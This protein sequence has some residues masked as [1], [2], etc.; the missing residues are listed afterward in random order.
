MDDFRYTYAVARIHALDATLLDK[1]FAS[2]MIAAEPDEILRMLGETV[3]GENLA[4]VENPWQ[5]ERAL[6]RE[7]GK[8]Y[9]LL[10]KICPDKELIRLFR[11]RY[12]FHNLKA[13]LKSR[14]TEI[15]HA[16]SVVDLGTCNIGELSAAVREND[17]RSI[18]EHLRDA[19]L[20]AQTEYDNVR[21]LESISYS[22]DRSMWEFMM[23]KARKQRNKIVTNLFREYINL[24]NIK[25]FFRTGEAGDDVKAFE[26]YFIP[27]GSYTIDFFLHL[28]DEKLGLFLDH[29]TKTHYE[30]PVVSEGLMT[31]PEEKSFWR[32]EVACD[33]F[34]LQQFHEM[35]MKLFSIAPLIYFL[36]RKI[37]ETRL[38]RA[39]MRC[40]SVGMGRT[41]IEERLRYLYV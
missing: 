26:R 36:L 21:R 33:N 23:T 34:I 22:C 38:I 30:R 5:V 24:T 1:A 11:A 40:K 29:L 31:W 13:M 18:P 25:T 19:A 27:G 17:Y 8:T 4:T 2:R 6:I 3:Y 7:L 35:R 32:L 37:A 15:A 9:D 28:M 16:D 39:I 20:K 41:E 12:D 14:I 10:E